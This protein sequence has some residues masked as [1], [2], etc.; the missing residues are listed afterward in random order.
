MSVPI[1]NLRSGTA[2]KRPD[3]S[4]LANGQIAINYNEGDPAV[5]FKGNSGALVKVSPTFVG[6]T[7]PNASPAS[8]GV[9]GNSVGETWLDTSTTPPTFKIFDG[10]SFVLA[11]GAGG[12][13]TGGGSDEG[14]IEFDKVVTTDYTISS[15]K[16]ALSVGDLTVN[17][18]VTLTV[19]N[20]S[21]LIVL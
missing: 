21:K 9:S 3:P 4:N 19:P 10:T 2:N 14:V 18:S 7:A 20:T 8:G 16:N 6:S 12:G 1:Q 15:S 13:A 17:N 11:G 5:Y